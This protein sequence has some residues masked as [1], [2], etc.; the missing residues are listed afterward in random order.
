MNKKIGNKI[1]N[2]GIN[3]E[4]HNWFVSSVEEKWIETEL[5]QYGVCFHHCRRLLMIYYL[6]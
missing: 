1:I 3:N 6:V 4:S 5:K 2:Q